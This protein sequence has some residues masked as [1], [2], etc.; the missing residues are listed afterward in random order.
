MRIDLHV[1]DSFDLEIH[2]GVAG[3]E[4]QHVIE[5]ADSGIDRILARTVEVQPQRDLGFSCFSFQ[6]RS[7]VRL[8]G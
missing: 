3:K 6:L 2:Q 7:S 8:H 5:K 4:D 1:S